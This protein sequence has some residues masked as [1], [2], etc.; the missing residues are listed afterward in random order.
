LLKNCVHL[1]CDRHLDTNF[2]CQTYGCVSSQHTFRY[3][4]MH[5]GNDVIKFAAAP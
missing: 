5:A 1:L 4:P 2:M 3:H